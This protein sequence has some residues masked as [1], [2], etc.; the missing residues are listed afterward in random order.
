MDMVTPLTAAPHD[1]PNVAYGRVG[2][3]LINLGTP[4]ALTDQSVR[5]YLAEFLSDRRVVDYPA[6][7]WQP[8]LRGIILNTR[9]KKTR[10]AYGKI[11]DQETDESPLRRHTREQAEKLRAVLPD[12]LVVDWAMRYGVP[13]IAGRLDGMAEEGCDRILLVPLYPQYSATTTGT[14]NDAA[15]LWAMKQAWQPALRTMPAF[16]DDPGLIEALVGTCREHIPEG[17]ERI[18]LSFHGLPQRYFRAGDPYHCH[19]QKTA[20]LLREAM[21]WDDQFAPTAFQSKFGPEKWLEPSTESLVKAAGEEGLKKIA[22]ITPGFVSD[23]IETLEEVGI[24]LAETFTEHGGEELAAIP[25]LNASDDFIEV[26]RKLIL[27]E[28]SGWIS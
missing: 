11:W 10:A 9:P 24:G 3:L 20:R 4:E 1:H 17:C 22:V 23:C 18:I 2:V 14:A 7:L 8:V 6:I 13:G 12:G 16:H 27:R 15:Y 19:C 26:M 28:L 21:G 25:C 5:S